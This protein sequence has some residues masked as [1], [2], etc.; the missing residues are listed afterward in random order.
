MP[1]RRHCCRARG[2]T[3]LELMIALVVIGILAAIAYP[4]YSAQIVKSRRSDA[5]QALVE[6]AQK[7]ERYYSE[8]GTYVGAA[9]GAGGIYAATSGG[10]YYNLAIASQTANGFTI[11]A[12]PAGKQAGD[13]CG[14][15]GYD[16]A[17]NRTVNGGSLDAAACW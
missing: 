17:G 4:S 5:K 9:I 10:G 15:F 1:R 8:R 14:S 7:L 13:A 11:T 3:L 16:Q 2:F 6:L 12:A